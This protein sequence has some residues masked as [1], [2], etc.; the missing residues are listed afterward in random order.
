M[1]T[2]TYVA[3]AKTVLTGTTASVSFSSIVNTYTDLVLLISA[4]GDGAST[5]VNIKLN[6]TFTT[7]SS[8]NVTGV[9]TTA[10]SSNT[11]GRS[12][13]GGQSNST[14]TSNTFS[15]VEAYFLNYAGSAYKV[16]SA[17]MARENNS[18]T[19]NL[20]GAQAFLYQITAAI[21]QIELIP[22]SGNF[23][24]GSRFDL[25]GIKNS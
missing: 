5:S 25:Y 1:P 3:I 24:S 21:N 10:A 19:V 15:N 23:V 20:V 22:G 4:R 9:G 7:D 13:Q 16:I 17:S 14:D 11:S 8:T 6:G 2:P 18:S 12:I